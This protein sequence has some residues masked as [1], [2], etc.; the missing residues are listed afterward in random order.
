MSLP[1]CG[2]QARSV[3]IKPCPEH[4][5]GT[6]EIATPAC[7]NALWRAGTGFALATTSS[8]CFAHAYRQAGA[9]NGHFRTFYESFRFGDLI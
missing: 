2:R 8:N 9:R 4:S 1:A 6:L 7:R 5:E 3:A